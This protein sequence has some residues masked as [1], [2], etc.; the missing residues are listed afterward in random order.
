MIQQPG[1][2]ESMSTIV[3]QVQ[4]ADLQNRVEVLEE[5][6]RL[7]DEAFVREKMEHRKTREK[8]G[9]KEL[10]I[11][12]LRATNEKLEEGVEHNKTSHWL[13]T[14][15]RLQAEITQLR[16]ENTSYSNTCEAQR[17]EIE[18][19]SRVI[20]ESDATIG[21][22]KRAIELQG[23]ENRR[24]V[25]AIEEKNVHLRQE[26]E[27]ARKAV[28]ERDAQITELKRLIEL[29]ET[30]NQGRLEVA[31]DVRQ[32]TIDFLRVKSKE[33]AKEI[34]EL[35][36]EVNQKESAKQY[37]QETIEKL[38]EALDEQRATIEG[39]L[40]KI[41]ELYES[42]ESL[43]VAEIEAKR[44]VESLKKQ[45]QAIFKATA[46]AFKE[47]EPCLPSELKSSIRNLID[48]IER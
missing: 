39:N 34:E 36:R 48:A 44:E 29:Q 38:R 31:R 7:M 8:V 47:I 3:N 27:H 2:F 14:I 5:E 19:K 32:D 26:N 22:L 1:N 40:K 45:R 25:E 24:K 23:T 13:K 18:I 33:A 43:I 28:E 4:N 30:E 9:N 15:E 20:R 6:L 41:T 42:K 16:N 37:L 12:A 11:E 46:Q 21:S 35:K 10:I 17:A